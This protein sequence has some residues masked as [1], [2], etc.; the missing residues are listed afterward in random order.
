[1]CENESKEPNLFNEKGEMNFVKAGNSEILNFIQE[2]VRKKNKLDKD[3]AKLEAQVK[4]E[5]SLKEAKLFDDE[6]VK[7]FKTLK[8]KEMAVKRKLDDSKVSENEEILADLENEI[9]DIN[10]EVN[11][12]VQLYKLKNRP[13]YRV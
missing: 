10:N 13:V 7:S 5:A 4:K 9:Y 1:M 6:E 12:A 2:N 8:E 11:L 3:L